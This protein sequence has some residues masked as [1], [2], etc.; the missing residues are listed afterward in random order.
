M[1]EKKKTYLKLFGYYIHKEYLYSFLFLALFSSLSFV[2]IRDEGWTLMGTFGV[3]FCGSLTMLSLI[4]LILY[5]NKEKTPSNTNFWDCPILLKEKKIVFTERYLFRHSSISRTKEITAEQ[6][7]ELNLKRFPLELVINRNEVIFIQ[8][9][10]EEDLIKFCK[11]NKVP[12]VERFDIWQALSKPYLDT[13]LDEEEHEWLY[14]NL[15]KNGI[16]RHETKSIRKKIRL[17]LLSATYVTWEWINYSQADVL[18]HKGIKS[19]KFYWFTM[20]V[21]LRNF[22]PSKISC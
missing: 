5:R 12:I 19:K 1:G 17:A 18:L 11:K 14:S 4:L 15:E 21:A 10:Y 20:D 22:K 16:Y 2:V 7:N 3:F 9:K 6:I 8:N 13:E